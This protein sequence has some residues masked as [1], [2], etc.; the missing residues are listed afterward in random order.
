MK[1][2]NS[3]TLSILGQTGIATGLLSTAPLMV[4][5]ENSFY[6]PHQTSWDVALSDPAVLNSAAIDKV[7]ITLTDY[8][9]NKYDYFFDGN[10]DISHKY[11][12]ETSWYIDDID[13]TDDI[14]VVGVK[15]WTS[16]EKYTSGIY[17]PAT[18]ST[19][20]IANVDISTYESDVTNYESCTTAEYQI[21]V[22]TKTGNTGSGYIVVT[23]INCD[24]SATTKSYF[25][26]DD[27]IVVISTEPSKNIPTYTLNGNFSS[28]PV[29]IDGISIINASAETIQI[30][31]GG[32]G[33]N[34]YYL[35]EYI[36]KFTA[37]GPPVFK[38]KCYSNIFSQ[39]NPGIK[40]PSYNSDT[41]TYFNIKGVVDKLQYPD[42][43]SKRLADS[44]TANSLN[45]NTPLGAY[46]TY[47]L[48]FPDYSDVYLEIDFVTGTPN[49]SIIIGNGN[50]SKYRY[51]FGG[52][53]SD[54][55]YI[56]KCANLAL[57]N[58]K[59][60]LATNTLTNDG[61]KYLWYIVYRETSGDYDFIALSSYIVPKTIYSLSNLNSTYK[62]V[63]LSDSRFTKLKNSPIENGSILDKKT[64]GILLIQNSV[65]STDAIKIVKVAHYMSCGKVDIYTAKN[66]TISSVNNNTITSS[67]HGLKNGDCVKFSSALPT[68]KENITD[69]NGNK[70]V[71][72][73][74]TNTFN[75]YFDNKFVYPANVYN[76][77]NVTGVLWTANGPSNWKYLHTLYSPQ[78]KNGYGLTEALRVV[79]ET[80]VSTS[81]P[82]DR[83]IESPITDGGKIKP[84]A[85]Y[86]SWR[87]WNNFYPFIREG[88]EKLDNQELFNGNKFGANCRIIK[89]NSNQFILA[90]SEPGAEKSFK[91]FDDFI[92]KIQQLGQ[93]S[94]A[95]LPYNQYVIPNYLPYGR[96]HFYKITKSPY[97]IEYLKSTSANDDPSYN[98]NGWTYYETLNQ[99]YKKTSTVNSYSNYQITISDAQQ[100]Y[101]SSN[102]NYW[103][104]SRFYS[105]PDK[106]FIFNSS[107]NIEIPDSTNISYCNQFAFAD[108]FGKAAAFELD[109]SNIRGVATTNVKSASFTTG[110][111]VNNLDAL[112]KTFSYN[113][114]TNTVTFGKDIISQSLPTAA[115]YPRKSQ[116]VELSNFG[117][118]VDFDN[119][120]VFVG[121][122]AIVRDED[123]IYA[124][125]RSGVNYTPLQTIISPGNNN[126]GDYIIAQND[127]LLTDRLST[128]DDSGNVTKKLSYIYVYKRDPING[129]YIFQSRVSPTIDLSSGQYSIYGVD[130]Y[131]ITANNSYDDT[132]ESSATLKHSL[133]GKY[134]LYNNSL[135]TRDYR[136]FVYYQF[137][138]KTR[139]FI[140]KNHSFAKTDNS[141]VTDSII[142]IAP[143]KSSLAQGAAG[144]Y[145]ET[146]Q[147]LDGSEIL[148]SL[149]LEFMSKS[150][151][152]PQ[153]LPLFVKSIEGYGSGVSFLY[154]LGKEVFP[155]N[156]TGIS[157]YAEGPKINSSGIDLYTSGPTQN[158]SGI[159]LY[160][161]T[162]RFSNGSTNLR[163]N[164]ELQNGELSLYLAQPTPLNNNISLYTRDWR[165]NNTLSLEISTNPRIKSDFSLY[166]SSYKY[167]TGDGG[168]TNKLGLYDDMA[169][170]YIN[171][172]HTGVPNSSGKFNLYIQTRPYEDIASYFNLT[173]N[174]SI[175]ETTGNISLFLQNT[176]G[177]EQ[178][179]LPLYFKG[180]N[181]LNG[182]NISSSFNLFIKETI[183]GDIPLIVYNNCVETGINMYIRSAYMDNSGIDLVTS[184]IGVTDGGINNYIFGTLGF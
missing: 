176:P 24:G 8:S 4:Q 63:P 6:I 91:I 124:Y 65:I 159:D 60:K 133:Y 15:D 165:V 66:G 53:L 155:S 86:N 19:D 68:S 174:P 47:E 161:E 37:S 162:V 75:I 178:S 109:G 7:E 146:L 83:A 14:A 18:L 16:S 150:Y 171:S 166:M 45:S 58:K 149:S 36:R 153:Y 184:G 126:F 9:F 103:A 41:F 117:Y 20:V 180:P 90:I 157:L 94:T 70:Y 67:G 25:V 11:I 137:D 179:S 172:T 2:K 147:V 114:S 82:V 79:S 78:G 13:M 40:Y 127:F 168:F 164:P 136:E 12:E 182:T 148:S 55:Q 81:D 158:Y 169:Y 61:D 62:N 143:S 108:H 38:Y 73:V 33:S 128:I 170:L 57:S 118:N 121:W 72:G 154:S 140:P 130:D 69:L 84:Q 85:Y 175:N 29:P 145:I 141:A 88:A 95:K 181:F 17:Y 43:L 120:K 167:E 34:G 104:G 107:Y 115:T 71:S 100:T 93:G 112:S 129:Q 98:R 123:Y 28:D 59:Y 42:F 21:N 102:H 151:P 77:R 54:Q 99:A 156:I 152:N 142:R 3:I 177:K 173:I 50:K 39:F 113:I 131:I 125:T 134:D 48:E 144:E 106:G 27:V 111:R 96:M 64:S 35:G 122:P 92:I 49:D 26:P 44:N 116:N 52:F 139:K 22:D 74:T 56:E 31:R 23:T 138:S 80:G 135:V 160:L 30:E 110:D 101:S 1:K 87:S 183:R 76:L 105:W 119:K 51:S 163:I 32:C 97:S 89:I 5:A 132:T 46:P 10:K